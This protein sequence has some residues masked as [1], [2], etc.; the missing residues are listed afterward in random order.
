MVLEYPNNE[1]PVASAQGPLEGVAV[2]YKPLL[3]SLLSFTRGREYDKNKVYTK[4]DLRTRTPT[5]VI[6]WMNLKTFGT[7]DPANNANLT[8]CRRSSRKYWKKAS[9][10]FLM[11]NR[12]IV[13]VSGRALRR[14]EPNENHWSEQSYKAYQEQED[15]SQKA[16]ETVKTSKTSTNDWRMEDNEKV[17]SWII[18]ETIGCGDVL[19]ML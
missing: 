13:W 11:P 19:C 12:L 14:R 15:G 2:K 16:R 5:D 18:M 10:S 3:D 7:P 6:W 4:R 9:R 8:E 1:E 17:Y